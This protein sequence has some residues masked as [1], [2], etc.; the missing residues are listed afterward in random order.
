MQRSGKSCTCIQNCNFVNF[1]LDGGQWPSNSYSTKICL[2]KDQGLPSVT[3]S[4]SPSFINSKSQILSCTSLKT[5]DPAN[6]HNLDKT[7]LKASRLIGFLGPFLPIKHLLPIYQ[8]P[9]I[10]P[11]VTEIPHFSPSNREILLHKFSKPES[12]STSD[13]NYTP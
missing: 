12:I 13:D 1:I 8:T 7:D 6:R 3:L 2:S 11:S 4:L 9:A 5:T 10:S